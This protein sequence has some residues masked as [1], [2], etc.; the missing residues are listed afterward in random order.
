MFWLVMMACGGQPQ[1]E[2]Q[3]KTAP[4]LRLRWSLGP[5]S[6]CLALCRRRWWASRLVSSIHPFLPTVRLGATIREDSS[7]IH[8]STESTTGTAFGCVSRATSASLSATVPAGS[9]GKVGFS[10]PARPMRLATDIASMAERM[11]GPAG[12]SPISSWPRQSAMLR[13][14]GR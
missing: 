14:S 12:E 5:P 9:R 8:G 4:A 10:R 6:L 13:D 2:P 1:P 7:P 3:P 11:A